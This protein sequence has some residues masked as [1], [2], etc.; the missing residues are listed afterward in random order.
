MLH[1]DL[2]LGWE[3]VRQQRSLMPAIEPDRSQFTKRSFV[4]QR[5]RQSSLVSSKIRCIGAVRKYGD[6]RFVSALVA[7]LTYSEP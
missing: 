4:Q 6:Q 7:F 1:P 3:A 5:C 2:T